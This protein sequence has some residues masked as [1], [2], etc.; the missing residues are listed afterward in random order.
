MPQ[1]LII[2]ITLVLGFIFGYIVALIPGTSK[3]RK[4]EDY[5]QS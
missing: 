2:P 4:D 5:K 1:M 3:K